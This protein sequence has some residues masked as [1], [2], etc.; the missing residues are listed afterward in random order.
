L[1]SELHELSKPFKRHV[2]AVRSAALTLPSQLVSGVP[3]NGVGLAVVVGD[4][5][6]VAVDEGVGVGL[7][8]KEAVAGGVGDGVVV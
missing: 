5:V 4:T 1:A 6:E 8:V 3:G 2:T 7:A